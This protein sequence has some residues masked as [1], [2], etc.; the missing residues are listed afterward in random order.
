[1]TLTEMKE[2]LVKLGAAA[3]LKELNKERDMLLSLL[4]PRN[5]EVKKKKD[6]LESVKAINRKWSKEQRAKFK[7]TMRKK[8]VTNRFRKVAAGSVEKDG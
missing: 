3:R 5:A 4:S 8:K 1:M 6:V 2:R 7:A